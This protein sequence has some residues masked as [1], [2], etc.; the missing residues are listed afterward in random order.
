[1][2]AKKLS[3]RLAVLLAI[4]AGCWFVT[5]THAVAQRA[6]EKVLHS[7]PDPNGTGPNAG[8][9]FD[10]A[11]N[12][13][14]T[15]YDSRGGFGTVFE[16]TPLG[17]GLW[18]ETTLHRFSHNDGY[19]PSGVLVFD[20][21]GNLYGTTLEGGTGSGTG[22]S[23]R[24]AGCGTVFELSPAAG[25]GWAETL[26]LSFDQIDGAAPYAGLIFDGLGNLYG[27]TST[28]GSDSTRASGTVFELSPTTGGVWTETVLHT[29]G[30]NEGSRDGLEPH[31][32]LIFDAVGNLYGT[33]V[34]G[35]TEGD[36]TVFEL[37]PHASGGWAETVL[38]NFN[39]ENGSSPYSTLIF[40][41]AGNLYGTTQTG[42]TLGGGTVFEL[43][44]AAG[45][46][47][48]ETVLFN[49]SNQESRYVAAG[50]LIFD[51]AGNLYGALDGGSGNC[52][53]GCGSIFKLSNSA[54]VWTE[55]GLFFFD[56]EDG[57]HPNASL[58]FDASGNLYGT[59]SFGGA[60]EDG[61]VFEI[62][63]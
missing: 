50:S 29:F 60:Q 14:G 38:F 11:G 32:G 1:M 21:S 24:R 41:A 18:T 26:L 22:C 30:Y 36:G 39:G 31:G 13:Y 2:R 56:G 17:N 6:Q 53:A 34:G 44:P 55:T 62:V 46:D 42:G 40:D 7:F 4:L 25:G 52:D 47:W 19:W 8:V 54:G 12:L 5:S 63:P 15:T 33:T 43:S 9:I 48:T 57:F 49:F 59:T 45:G 37:S 27:T 3:I 58:I 20:A 16:L 35:G 23:L 61:T 28:G 10:A 51:A